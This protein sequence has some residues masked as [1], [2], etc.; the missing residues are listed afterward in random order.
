M[1][2][3]KIVLTNVCNGKTSHIEVVDA[4]VPIIL[5]NLTT[6]LSGAEFEYET[7]V[8]ASDEV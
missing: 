1:K 2:K 7:K 6:L 3:K 8:E 4:W 5:N